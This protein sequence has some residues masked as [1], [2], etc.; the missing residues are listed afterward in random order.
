[1]SEL[2]T[3]FGIEPP[4]P[5][6]LDIPDRCKNCAPLLM[7]KV[8]FFEC[9]LAALSTAAIADKAMDGMPTEEREQY[10]HHLEEEHQVDLAMH[11]LTVEGA[12]A[13]LEAE[14][15]QELASRLNYIDETRENLKQRIGAMTASCDGPLTMRAQRN[16]REYKVRICTTLTDNP[17]KNVAV[18]DCREL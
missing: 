7:A 16:G 9:K 13:E 12:I 4:E 10:A 18:I 5:K 3:D 1:M 17:Y 11:N 2:E 15:R 8:D 14:R 6:Q